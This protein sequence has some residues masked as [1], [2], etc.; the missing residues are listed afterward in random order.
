VTSE[1]TEVRRGVDSIESDAGRAY[2][3]DIESGQPARSQ[4]ESSSIIEEVGS[5]P[6]RA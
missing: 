4:P 1:I 5:N 3:I 2:Q 6:Q